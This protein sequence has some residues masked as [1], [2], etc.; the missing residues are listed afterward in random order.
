MTKFESYSTGNVQIDDEI[1][2]KLSFRICQISTISLFASR[3]DMPNMRCFPI[4]GLK[5]Q[6]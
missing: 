4:G 2:E 6:H 3:Y 5:K 1:E